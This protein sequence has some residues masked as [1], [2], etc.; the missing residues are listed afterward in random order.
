MSTQTGISLRNFLPN[1]LKIPENI[2]SLITNNKT[3][4]VL[5]QNGQ[6]NVPYAFMAMTTLVAGTFTYVTY[7]DYKNEASKSISETL[8]TLQSNDLFGSTSSQE[9]S[10]LEVNTSGSVNEDSLTFFKDSEPEV[11][12]EKTEPEVEKEKT[13][14]EVEKK[15][16]EPG[17]EYKLGGK[18]RRRTKKRRRK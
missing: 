17:E 16:D 13:E 3:L 15:K 2:A 14:P 7:S 11:E 6:Y 5:I 10:S 4:D 8:D 12:K 1:L 9:N 18:K